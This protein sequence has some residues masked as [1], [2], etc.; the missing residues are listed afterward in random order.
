MA[1]Y[2]P[3]T[4]YEPN[5][6]DVFTCSETAERIFQDE[7]GELSCSFD[8]EVDDETIGRALSSPLFIQEREEPADRRQVY[9]SYEEVC[10]QL[11]PYSHMRTYFAPLT[12]S[13]STSFKPILTEEV[14]RN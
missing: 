11:S 9:H 14:S 10:C 6:L 7:S 8:A 12:R 4:G 1:I 3:F 13:R 2:R 5:V